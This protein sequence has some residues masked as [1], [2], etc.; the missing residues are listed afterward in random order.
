MLAS[1]TAC[2]EAPSLSQPLVIAEGARSYAVTDDAVYFT[3]FD[4]TDRLNILKRYTWSDGAT[5]ELDRRFGGGTPELLAS[6]ELVW[7]GDSEKFMLVRGGPPVNAPVPAPPRQFPPDR[8][9]AGTT[10]FYVG[11]IPL[12]RQGVLLGLDVETLVVEDWGLYAGNS[13][14]QEEGRFKYARTTDPANHRACHWMYLGQSDG[15]Y[16]TCYD[17][18]AA[19]NWYAF[20]TEIKN[21]ALEG[22][23]LY[24]HGTLV[25]RCEVT[26]D[27]YDAPDACVPYGDLGAP[28]VFDI[29][30]RDGV[31]WTS[32]TERMFRTDGKQVAT[33]NV[34]FTAHQL[35]VSGP[36]V[37]AGVLEGNE[38]RLL[39][40]DLP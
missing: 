8:A 37:V 10:V 9:I 5:V 31:V 16:V 36:Y 23:Y 20:K 6:P 18:G 35:D 26:P 3:T 40:L 15:G 11:A 30:A 1:L 13:Y 34:D 38:H 17:L 24:R 19:P 32:G 2:S 12:E 22:D 28:E 39:A 7:W 4:A 33:Y 29:V 21:L 14:I 25:E 27:R